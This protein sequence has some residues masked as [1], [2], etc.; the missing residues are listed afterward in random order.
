MR[1]KKKDAF[2]RFLC[3]WSL[4]HL[5]DYSG[6]DKKRCCLALKWN[7]WKVKSVE[8]LFSFNYH[9]K[10]HPKLMWVHFPLK[11]T[12]LNKIGCFPDCNFF[13]I[14]IFW[15]ASINERNTAFLSWPQKW[16]DNNFKRRWRS[17]V[18][19]CAKQIINQWT[20]S[21]NKKNKIT[22][23]LPGKDQ[24]SIFTIKTF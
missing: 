18:P 16:S 4:L 19:V 23:S 24:I 6:S 11:T 12:I 22:L 8:N 14:L 20:P 1:W 17:M 5:R 21:R 15:E 2:C 7:F 10:K 13:I 9:L 3:H